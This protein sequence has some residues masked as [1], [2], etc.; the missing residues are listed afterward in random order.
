[1]AHVTMVGSVIGSPRQHMVG[2]RTITTKK[3]QLLPESRWAAGR[4]VLSS[5]VPPA[6]SRV[7]RGADVPDLLMPNT[8]LG[9]I[10]VRLSTGEIR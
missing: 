5:P 6:L 7:P 3:G 9:A 2:E 1:M 4:Q 10:K 8:L